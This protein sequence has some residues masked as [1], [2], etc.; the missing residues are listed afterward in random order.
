MMCVVS[1]IRVVKVSDSRPRVDSA[2]LYTRH[3]TFGD[4][5]RWAKQCFL[6]AELRR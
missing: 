2:R 1:A 3:K 4:V 6:K 5:T